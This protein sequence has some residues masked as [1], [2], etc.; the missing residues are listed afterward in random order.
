MKLVCPILEVVTE[1]E[2]TEYSRDQW[3]VVRCRTTGLVFLANPPSY[4]QLAEQ[5]A[6][7][8]SWQVES[9][10][11]RADEPLVSRL[12]SVAKRLKM[13]L[14]PRRNKML[15]LI[16]QTVAT[17]PAERQIR[18]IDIGCGCGTLMQKVQERLQSKGHEAVPMGIEVSKQ[19]ASI[20][21][22]KVA[23]FGGKVLV[24]G[25]VDGVMQ[26]EADSIDLV[27]MSSF[28]EH[29]FQPMRLFREL[30][31]VLHFDG[32]IVL[33][34]PNFASWNRIVRGRKW[35]GFRHP[36]HVSYFTPQT[37]TTLAEAEKF[38]I[39]RQ[40]LRERFPLNDNMYAVLK[41]AA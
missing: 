33:K 14:L 17:Q 34:V 2:P 39:S 31:R 23:Q 29:E 7:E 1:V 5:F 40:G 20:A 26:L 25:S 6:W 27:I 4:E 11:R 18:F 16:C 35:S 15:S 41:K 28:L 22:A 19:L 36:D 9:R 8:K 24:Q 21:Q 37:L 10:R 12:S 32:S 13:T 3:L 30:R 38:T